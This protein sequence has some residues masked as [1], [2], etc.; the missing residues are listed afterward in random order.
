MKLT[1]KEATEFLSKQF[2]N[3]IEI[4]DGSEVDGWII[5]T[6]TNGGHPSSLL[7][8]DKILAIFSDGDISELRANDLYWVWD[9]TKFIHVV[10]YRKII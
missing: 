9:T 2:G 3:V 10:K 5:N 4:V 1:I 7:S 6:K 8:F